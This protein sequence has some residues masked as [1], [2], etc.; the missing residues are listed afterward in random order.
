MTKQNTPDN[1]L[2]N[3]ETRQRFRPPWRLIVGLA[4]IAALAF[5][6]RQHFGH[7][8]AQQGKAYANW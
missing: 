8:Q 2:G 5:V 3:D 7:G 6:G 1:T 4:A